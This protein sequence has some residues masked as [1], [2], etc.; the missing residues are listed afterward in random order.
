MKKQLIT[1]NKRIAI[2]SLLLSLFTLET[3]AQENDKF[4]DKEEIYSFE[5][6]RGNFSKKSENYFTS[7][8]L[9]ATIKF[10]SETDYPGDDSFN[11]S[12]QEQFKIAKKGIKVT[13]QVIKN[14]KFTI[15]GIDLSG[16]I[17]YIRG[18]CES[19]KVSNNPN[20]FNELTWLWTKT[21]IVTFT[22]PPAN[23]KI[24]DKNIETF[25]KTYQL[26]FGLL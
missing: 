22:Y 25:I 7:K 12:L 15:S 23:K 18:D 5:L 17:V 24:M 1:K 10:R 8:K 2:L 21:M 6:P 4:F 26:N 11:A 20:N 3:F 19:L 13:Y 14:G 9:S 16:N